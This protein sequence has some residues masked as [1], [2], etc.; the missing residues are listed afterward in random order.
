MRKKIIKELINELDY[1]KG[2]TI[3]D[4]N[5]GY[6]L[7][8]HYYKS[9]TVVNNYYIAQE[10]VRENWDE[11]LDEI[12]DMREDDMHIPN[13]FT[14]PEELMLQIYL[15]VAYNTMLDLK[16]VHKNEGHEILLDDETIGKIKKELEIMLENL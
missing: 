11:I 1:H 13:P 4:I 7:F 15:E 14:D 6:T 16:T 2:E 9:G 8:N 3:A 10:W 5:L 12:V